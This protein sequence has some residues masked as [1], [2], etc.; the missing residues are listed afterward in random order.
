MGDLDRRSI[1]STTTATVSIN[2]IQDG[3]HDAKRRKMSL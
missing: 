3:C 1:P 2:Q